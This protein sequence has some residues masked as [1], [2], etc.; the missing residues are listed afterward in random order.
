MDA[1]IKGPDIGLGEGVIEGPLS[2]GVTH[3]LKFR[4][5]GTG[6]YLCG[7]IGRNELRVARL[8]LGELVLERVE[9]FR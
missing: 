3:L 2:R 5:R 7:R 9:R 8:K 6:D 4:Q 1:F